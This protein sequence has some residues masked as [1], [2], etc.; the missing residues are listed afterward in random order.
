MEVQDFNPDANTVAVR[1]SKGGKARH[2]V[3]TPE[4]AEFFRQHCAGRD[5][6]E[7]MFRCVNDTTWNKSDQSR[8]M[9]AGCA[10]ARITPPA[11][12]GTNVTGVSRGVLGS[13]MPPKVEST[14]EGSQQNLA[15][16]ASKDGRG[17]PP[18]PPA[19]QDFLY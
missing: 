10:R 16:C 11:R 15:N 5:S 12:P 19:Q 18:P 9:R 17:R 4:G 13:S 6:T 3:L 2:V 7:A 14:S 8:P 1:K